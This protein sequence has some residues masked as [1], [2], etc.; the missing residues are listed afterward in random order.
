MLSQLRPALVATALLTLVTGVAYPL[1]VTGVA[2]LMP[3][4]AEGS[5]IKD[6]AGTVVGSALI[7]QA[8]TKPEY[9]H[10]RPSG[11]GTNGYD[12]SASSGSNLGPLNADLAKRT[13]D[14]A[15]AVRAE[16]GQSRVPEDAV[17][18]SGSGLDPDI[19]PLYADLQAARIAKARGACRSA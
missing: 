10:G 6:R 13:M 8:F 16:T 3:A 4:A 2:K 15:A 19:S 11:A 7:G 5:M 14:G 9:L 18:T 1:V 12:A 17:T